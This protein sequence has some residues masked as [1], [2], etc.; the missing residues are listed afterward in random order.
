MPRSQKT[1]RSIVQPKKVQ[2]SPPAPVST[3]S[4]QHNVVIEK[5]GFFSNI[6]T[7]FGLGAGQA[8]AH[9]VFRSDPVVKHVHE[10]EIVKSELPKEFIQ[11][12]KDNNNNTDICKQFLT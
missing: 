7:G 4:V 3:P 12:M 8:I 9:N 11:C 10:S 6:F 5:P 2:S 1:Y